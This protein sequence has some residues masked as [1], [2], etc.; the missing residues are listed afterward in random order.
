MHKVNATYH[1]E[2]TPVWGYFFKDDHDDVVS[3]EVPWDAGA[4]KRGGCGV[5]ANAILGTSPANAPSG[6]RPIQL[7]R[8]QAELGGTR[9]KFARHRPTLA[10]VAPVGAIARNLH[11]FARFRPI[12]AASTSFGLMLT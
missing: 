9:A 3:I 11:D 1:R 6:T 4:R 8:M 5:R 7:R 12:W 10:P 2:A